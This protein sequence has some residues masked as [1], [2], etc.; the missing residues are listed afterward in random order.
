[1][2]KTKVDKELERL[3]AKDLPIYR[4]QLELLR[5]LI[6]VMINC[7]RDVKHTIAQ[8]VVN[9]ATKQLTLI[10]AIDGVIALRE[11]NLRLFVNHNETIG[12]LLKVLSEDGYINSKWYLRTIEPLDSVTRQAKGWLMSVN[13]QNSTGND[14]ADQSRST[15]VNPL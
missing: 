6:R 4:K 10:D 9:I 3:A 5:V 8:Q 1:M 13:K 12:Q 15:E 14:C 11:E 7:S 2:A